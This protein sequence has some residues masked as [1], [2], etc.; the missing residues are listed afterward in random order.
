CGNLACSLLGWRAS[1][2]AHGRPQL[3]RAG[4]AHRH[5]PFGKLRPRYR[6]AL[7]STAQWTHKRTL[8]FGQH[9][10]RTP[11]HGYEPTREAAMAAFTKEPGG[12]S[13]GGS[14]QHPAHLE[15]QDCTLVTW[16]RSVYAPRT[17]GAY[18][19]HHRTAGIAGRTAFYEHFKG[20]GG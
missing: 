12:R 8:A 19:S 9:E 1:R 16:Y 14:N 18:D 7:V 15:R 20:L 3:G 4:H 17:G 13:S 11:T 2:L 10:D 5:P 6:G